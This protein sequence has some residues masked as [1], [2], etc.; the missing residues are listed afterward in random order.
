VQSRHDQLERTKSNKTDTFSKV[1][2]PENIL[3]QI[4]DLLNVAKINVL[5]NYLWL[6]AALCVVKCL[7][8]QLVYT[9]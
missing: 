3:D 6:E 5:K 8:A 2:M 7:V 9:Q 4:S 1:S